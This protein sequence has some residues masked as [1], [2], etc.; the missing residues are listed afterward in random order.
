V[1][2]CSALAGR[3]HSIARMEARDGNDGSSQTKLQMVALMLGMPRSRIN[4]ESG[5][6]KMHQSPGAWTDAEDIVHSA[7]DLNMIFAVH[8]A[9]K[10][11]QG[12]MTEE[13]NELFK[14]SSRAFRPFPALTCSKQTDKRFLIFAGY[15]PRSC[16]LKHAEHLRWAP[17]LPVTVSPLISNLYSQTQ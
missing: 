2:F 13:N 15:F 5:S 7:S 6:D 12:P 8:L 17:I 4:C 14:S 11:F 9:P 3:K 1:Q 10:Q 16:S